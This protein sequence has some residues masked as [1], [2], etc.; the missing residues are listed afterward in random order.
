M[1]AMKNERRSQGR[2]FVSLALVTSLLT[3]GL[4]VFG[5]VVR[6]TDSGLGCGSSWPLCDGKVLPPL[7]NITAWIEW[8]HRLFAALIGIFGLATLFVAWHS[9]RQNNQIVLW[10]TGVGAI[11]FAVQSILGAIVV[12]FELPPTFV[13]L[14]LGTAMLLLASLLAAAVIAWYRPHSQPTGDYVRQ[15]AYLNA[16]FALIIILTGALVRGAGA[17]LACTEWPLC[18]ENVLWP[19]DSGQLA[20]IHM[21]HRL[22]VAALGVSLLILVWQV[23]RNRQDGLSRSLAV[24][25]FVAYLLQAGIGA[26]YVISVAGPEWGAAHVGMAALTWALLIILS[27]TESLDFATTADNQLETQWQA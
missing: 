11:L 10:L 24:G 18:F 14:H 20:M 1:T 21:L 25:A 15:L 4:I 16:V 13:T 5:A 22:A 2:T 23:L 8:L 6:V 26:L 19:V 17:T 27:V 3:L 7:D 12:L 9:Y